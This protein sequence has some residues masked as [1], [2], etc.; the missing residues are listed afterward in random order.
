MPSLAA[1]RWLCAAWS[2]RAATQRPWPI[3][4][5]RR[6][7]LPGYEEVLRALFAGDGSR[8]DALIRGWPSD[9]NFYAMILSQD[10][11]EADPS[12]RLAST[13]TG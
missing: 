3:A 13:S 9:V 10:A 11:F 4:F 8:F 7:D 1:P 6:G 12:R 5:A 2:T